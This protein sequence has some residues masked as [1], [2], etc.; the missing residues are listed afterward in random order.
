MPNELKAEVD[1]LVEMKKNLPE[2]E[3][4]P[5]IQIINDYIEREMPR[6]KMIAD[7]IDDVDKEWEPLNE[8]FRRV[9]NV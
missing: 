4:A 1:R 9:M 7:D 6:V 3:L 8:L 2:T 5:K